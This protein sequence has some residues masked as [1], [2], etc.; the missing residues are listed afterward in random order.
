MARNEQLIR[1]HKILQIL[2]RSRFGKTIQELRDDLVDEL[3]L[4]SIHT[5][6]VQRDLDALQAAGID[7]D[8]TD[9][10]RGKVWK[11]G[12]RYKQTHRINASAT[13]LIALSLG[14]ELMFPLGG[15]PFW[16]GIESFWNKI[17]EEIPEAVLNH[18]E[19][20]R[21]TLRVMGVPT[22]NYERHFGMIKSLNRAILEHR[23]CDVVYD[24]IGKGA[25]QREI[26]P[27]SMA[28]FQS[29]LYV[30]AA[31]CEDS[32][33]ETRIRSFKI[34][35]F[36][37]VDL[38]DKWFKPPSEEDI[39]QCLDHSLGIFVGTKA[40]NYRIRV[41]A[42]AA[43]WVQEDPW[44]PDQVVRPLKN[45]DVELT[46]NAAHDLEILPRVLQ[47]GRDAEVLSPASS[48]QAMQTMIADMLNL[49]S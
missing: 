7:V 37:K 13:E 6:T 30:I 35:R 4:S 48:R 27:Y 23:V 42:R 12:P 16:V 18:Y 15:T 36:E 11:L 49:Y 22:K 39:N 3:G 32:N 14:R 28:L 29:S 44:H 9:M 1:Q 24:S 21:R 8:T 31:A 46:V 17:R 41:A 20:Y 43:R 26:E 2:E 33:A 38:L 47:L 25:R 10:Q 45:G 40:R 5:R 19:K 34:D